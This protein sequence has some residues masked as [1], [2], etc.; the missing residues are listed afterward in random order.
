[1]C[2][3]IRNKDFNDDIKKTGIKDVYC[4]I[5]KFP[6]A[7]AD[8]INSYSKKNIEDENSHGLVIVAGTNSLRTPRGQEEISDTEI[9]KMILQTGLHG[10]EKGVT[11]VF[12]SG[13]ILRKGMF[14]QR[15]IF[16]INKILKEQCLEL[17]FIYIDQSNI[18][19]EHLHE[20]GLHL[21]HEGTY[22]LKQNILK[23]L[24]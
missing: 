2:R 5:H 19:I 18:F 1:M 17:G 8:E 4:K 11:K 21:N 6:G 24:Y 22:I 20:D 3:S 15:R 12:V 16:N 23:A 9:A 13:L 7:T 10:R 14:F